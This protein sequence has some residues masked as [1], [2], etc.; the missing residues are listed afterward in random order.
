MELICSLLYSKPVSLQNKSAMNRSPFLSQSLTNVF[1][2]LV[3]SE[4]HILSEIISSPSGS[5]R[6][7]KNLPIILDFPCGKF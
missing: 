3:L 5:Y 4:N 7:Q 2:Y 6:R 1:L